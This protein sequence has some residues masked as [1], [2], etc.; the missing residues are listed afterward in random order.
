MVSIEC[1]HG[2]A[3]TV[4]WPIHRDDLGFP[5]RQLNDEVLL[6]IELVFEQF[7]SDWCA[8][9]RVVPE[10]T[11]TRRVICEMYILIVSARLLILYT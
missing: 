7:P 1:C 2:N 11:Q 5:Q 9:N 6:D 10:L 8:V 3:H 4:T